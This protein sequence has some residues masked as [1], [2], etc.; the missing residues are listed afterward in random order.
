MAAIQVKTMH[1]TLK[2]KKTNKTLTL[3]FNIQ[4]QRNKQQNHRNSAKSSTRRRI[5]GIAGVNVFTAQSE[6]D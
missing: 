2:K 1:E 3:K 5:C 4:Q 6:D